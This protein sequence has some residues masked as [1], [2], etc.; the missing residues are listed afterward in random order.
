MGDEVK[1]ISLAALMMNLRKFQLKPNALTGR[2]SVFSAYYGSMYHKVQNRPYNEYGTKI[3]Y[4][5]NIAIVI[6]K[7]G[8]FDNID[9]TII[10]SS[11]SKAV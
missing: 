8:R 9:S 3:A 5:N 7:I 11:A 10:T 6:L 4:E 2:I 1:N